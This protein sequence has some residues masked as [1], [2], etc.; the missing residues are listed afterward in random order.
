[1]NTTTANNNTTATLSSSSVSPAP[2]EAG[3]LLTPMQ[4]ARKLGISR[5]SLANWTRNKTVPMIKIGRVCRFDFAKVCAVLEKY[6]QPAV[7]APAAG[8]AAA[9]C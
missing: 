5:R 4:L 3:V 7:A 8:T 2:Q 9:G 1:M 6:E